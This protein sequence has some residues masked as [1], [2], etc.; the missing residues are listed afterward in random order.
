[1][2]FIARKHGRESEVE[3]LYIG[4]SGQEQLQNSEC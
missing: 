3:V 2:E 4:P 1:M